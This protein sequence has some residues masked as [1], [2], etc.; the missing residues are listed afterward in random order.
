MGL[1]LRLATDADI[2]FAYDTRKVSMRESVEAA[3]GTWDE[4]DQRARHAEAWRG[5][6]VVEII[7]RADQRIGW[8]GTSQTEETLSIDGLYV[9][10]EHQ[11]GGVGTWAVGQMEARADRSG[12]KLTLSVLKVNPAVNLYKRLGF[13]TSSESKTHWFMA[14]RA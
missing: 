14:L 2:D 11:G 4:A 8:V 5:E 7:E 13:R 10:P 3:Y 6:S 9:L 1:H 12:R